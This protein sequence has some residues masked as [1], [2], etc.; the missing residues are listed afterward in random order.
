MLSSSNSNHFESTKAMG[1]TKKNVVFSAHSRPWMATPKPDVQLED[2]DITQLDLIEP[3]LTMR[4]WRPSDIPTRT[5]AFF[6]LHVK[7]FQMRVYQ[8]SP[9]STNRPPLWLWGSYMD[10][11]IKRRTLYRWWP[12][13][14]VTWVFGINLPIQNAYP[15]EAQHATRN[16]NFQSE[17]G[18]FLFHFWIPAVPFPACLACLFSRIHV[19]THIEN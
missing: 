10:A 11:C 16:W 3:F 6:K 17:V 15:F 8:S 18:D 4:V 9:P 19:C 1:K 5:N 12:T 14:S 7:R 13:Y 2:E